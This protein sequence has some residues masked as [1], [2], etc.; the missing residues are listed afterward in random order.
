MSE[1]TENPTTT[2][3]AQAVALDVQDLP[4]LHPS[5]ASGAAIGLDHLLDVT[6]PV[7]VELG[8]ARMSIAG[9]SQLAPG[10]LITLDREAHEPVDILVSGKLIARGEVVTVGS[11][12]GVRITSMSG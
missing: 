8:H 1:I 6:V 3:P 11:R 5:K 9:L 4:A 7:T 12:Y 2:A 10:S